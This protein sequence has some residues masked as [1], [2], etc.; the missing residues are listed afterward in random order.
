MFSLLKITVRENSEFQ[1]HF[2]RASQAFNRLNFSFD[3]ERL[4]RGKQNFL[5][6]QEKQIAEEILF[7]IDAPLQVL[8][9]SIWCQGM[10]VITPSQACTLQW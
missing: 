2:K 1:S 4:F 7:A 5:R 3:T 10:D 8:T 6:D 9:L